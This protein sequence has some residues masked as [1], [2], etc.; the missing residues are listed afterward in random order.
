MRSV[1]NEVWDAF[2]GR[3]RPPCV[4]DADDYKILSC[5]QVEALLFNER[6][7]EIIRSDEW[8]AHSTSLFI[9]NSDAFLYFLPSILN[10]AINDHSKTN[11]IDVVLDELD[12]GHG[13]QYAHEWF[14]DR[15]FVMTKNEINALTRV[16]EF[17][18]QTDL[19]E[20][21][22]IVRVLLTLSQ[23]KRELYPDS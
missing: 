10:C 11:A 7:R 19:F 5:D 2:K 23:L 16:V 9:F 1:I 21:E 6:D 12:R 14:R 3:A 8:E 22:K 17:L 15:F 18:I 4:I 20:D 13:I